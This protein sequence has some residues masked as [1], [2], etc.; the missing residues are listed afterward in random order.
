M[1]GRHRDAVAHHIPKLHLQYVFE[2][3]L[4]SIC[5]TVHVF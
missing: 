2:H 4:Y 3:K 5:I 1:L